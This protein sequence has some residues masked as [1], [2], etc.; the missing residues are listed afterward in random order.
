MGLRMMGW[1]RSPPRS[2]GQRYVL[3]RQIGQG[4]MGAVWLADDEVLGREVAVKRVG[5][6]PGGRSP[7]LMRAQR[8]AKLAAKLNHPHVV[9]VFDFVTEQDEQ[10]LV[11]EY[12]DGADLAVL[13][14]HADGLLPDEAAALL[15]QV[16]EALA[17]AHAAGVVHRDV[18]PSNV[19]VTHDG[20]AKLADFGIARA[21][22]STM[23]ASGRVTGSPAYL[24][25][26]VV[27]GRPA[28][29]ASDVWSLGATL[30]QA[31]TGRTPY[32]TSDN[33]L[34]AMYRIVHEAPPRL[35]GADWPADLLETTMVTD[36][37]DRWP[38]S[39]VR[40]YL[41][42]GPPAREEQSTATLAPA[43]TD[44]MDPDDTDT[45]AGPGTRHEDAVP[46]DS[47]Q[48]SWLFPVLLVTAVLVLGVALG[49]LLL[50][51]ASTPTA[52]QPAGADSSRPPGSPSRTPSPTQSASDSAPSSS[53][54]TASPSVRTSSA[55]AAPP[56]GGG[57]AAA[58]RTFVTQYVDTALADPAAAWDQLSPRFQE[59]C[60]EGDEGSYT[61]Y[62]NTIATATLR[63]VTADPQQMTVT[64]TITW[65]PEGERGPEDEVVTLGLVAD[66]DDGYLIDYEL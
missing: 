7:D 35:S 10:W 39:R 38:M 40:D 9:A 65:D 45:D 11:M 24:A 61:G 46:E 16:A 63:D 51:P 17:A 64:Y 6:F 56:T 53:P 28:K 36:P 44:A 5:L 18:K 32:D 30:Y 49:W 57:D 37:A 58:M 62:W 12:V 26:E 8:E 2:I 59:D 15:A 66:D 52:E 14:E 33:V 3:R 21:R 34:S 54:S 41:R 55:T 4:G 50:R 42:A 43:T 48:R 60:C 31:L 19:L 20:T 25:P 47:P 1:M 13:A 23:T 29:E 22:D 27:S